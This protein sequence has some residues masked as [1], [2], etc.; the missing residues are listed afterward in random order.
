LITLTDDIP[1]RRRRLKAIRTIIELIRNIHGEGREFFASRAEHE[2]TE[3]RTRS[4]RLKIAK[5][6]EQRRNLLWPHVKAKA[7][8]LPSPSPAKI[9]TEL[10]K[11]PDFR[12]KFVAKKGVHKKFA[13]SRRTLEAD[14]RDLLA[15]FETE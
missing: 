15:D 10:C 13:A 4:A 2:H 14:V 7:S 9:V 8:E 11:R 1:D 12:N 3:I 5:R 6:V